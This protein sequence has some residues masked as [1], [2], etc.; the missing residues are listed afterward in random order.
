VLDHDLGSSFHPFSS[1]LINSSDSIHHETLTSE[2][3]TLWT[4]DE[5]VMC[6]FSR[7]KWMRG[8]DVHLV[9]IKG[10]VMVLSFSTAYVI[11]LF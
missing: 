6:I 7:I 3:E 11:L 9:R 5:V 2:S 8:G 1:V 10:A 4:V